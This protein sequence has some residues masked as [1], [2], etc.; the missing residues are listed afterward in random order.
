MERNERKVEA[1]K[2]AD[3]IGQ[4]ELEAAEDMYDNLRAG[5]FY[6]RQREAEKWNRERSKK[7]R[8]ARTV[9][10]E[11]RHVRKMHYQG[12]EYL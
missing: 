2:E 5:T 11:R 9:N 3:E 1:N 8:D 4:E 6:D 7:M 10:I 12:R